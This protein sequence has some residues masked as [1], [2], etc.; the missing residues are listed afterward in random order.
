[1]ANDRISKSR[2]DFSLL[3]KKISQV[4]KEK[5]DDGAMNVEFP[6]EII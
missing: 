4:E 6:P 1:M 5:L 2:I 3:F